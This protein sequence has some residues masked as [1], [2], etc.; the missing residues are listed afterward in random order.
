M[1]SRGRLD[2]GFVGGIVKFKKGVRE[3][4]CCVNNTLRIPL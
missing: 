1:D 2:N 3:G 4:T